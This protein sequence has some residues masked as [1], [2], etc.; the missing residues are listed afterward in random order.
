[1]TFRKNQVE[2]L[3]IVSK[4]VAQAWLDNQG[5]PSAPGGTGGGEG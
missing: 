4:A 2:V 3:A 1:M 5:T